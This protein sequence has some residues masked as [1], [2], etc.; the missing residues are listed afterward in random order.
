[1]K[2]LRVCVK[3]NWRNEPLIGANSHAHVDCAEPVVVAHHESEVS[4]ST[5]VRNPIDENNIK[6]NFYCKRRLN[7]YIVPL[8]GPLKDFCAL[9]LCSILK[10]YLM[11]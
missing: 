3:Y 9:N 10:T 7:C 6:S 1:M 4:E 11:Y 2:T 5:A 8:R